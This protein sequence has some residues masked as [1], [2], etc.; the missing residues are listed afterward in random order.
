MRTLLI[1]HPEASV[2]TAMASSLSSHGYQTVT[3]P[4]PWPPRRCIRC[5]VGYCPLTDGADLMI[6]D[7]NL[8]S[9]DRSGTAHN[10]ALESAEAQPDVPMLLAWQGDEPTSVRFISERVPNAHR[11]SLDPE[12]LIAQISRLIGR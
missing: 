12:E 6:Y 1:A 5:D 3:C 4:G 2:A 7:P 10:L 8:V 9:C 11:A